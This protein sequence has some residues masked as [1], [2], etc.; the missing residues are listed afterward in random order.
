M[1][2]SLKV[3]KKIMSDGK[4]KFNR[5][6]FIK[7]TKLLDRIYID[8]PKV[9]EFWQVE[10]FGEHPSI[11]AG[12]PEDASDR[13]SIDDPME[14]DMMEFIC[15]I[16]NGM[17]VL[18]RRKWSIFYDGMWYCDTCRNTETLNSPTLA[19]PTLPLLFAVIIE[20]DHSTQQEKTEEPVVDDH[21]NREQRLTYRFLDLSH[22]TRI[23]IA[24]ELGLYDPGDDCLEELEFVV[25]V[26]TKAKKYN[27]LKSL[28][29]AVES[30]H[31]GIIKYSNPY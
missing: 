7:L 25:S 29:D 4:K 9:K 17:D 27:I 6:S 19:G 22:V 8:N 26:F 13:Y 18:I 24:Q 14:E 16:K 10:T 1:N 28:W 20:Y 11:T 12:P 31:D 21:L 30:N 5:A 2:T 3:E 23:N 15:V